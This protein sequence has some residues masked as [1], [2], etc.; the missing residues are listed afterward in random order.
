MKFLIVSGP[1]REPIDP[2]RYLSNYSTGVMGERLEEAAKKRGHR[3]TAVR[4]PGDAET[5]REL[6]AKLQKLTPAHDALVMAAAV[7]DKRPVKISPAK[8]KKN[9]LDTVRLIDNPDILAT[10]ARK[11]SKKQ[12]FIGFALESEKFLENGYRKLVS[13]RLEAIFIQR[14]MNDSKPFGN[15]SL[16]A[17]LLTRD[18]RFRHF[19]R[20]DK[21]QAAELLVREAEDSFRH[22]KIA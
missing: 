13:K 5:A 11:K 2:V 19:R 1:T 17:Y 6:L 3:V 18:K 14:V 7:C 22:A 16:E 10:L 15:T 4:C 9:E 8:I 12:V 20:I 21:T